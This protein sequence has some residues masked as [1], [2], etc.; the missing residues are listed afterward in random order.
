MHF[1]VGFFYSSLL[2]LSFSLFA[3][4][5]VLGKR[6][7]GEEKKQICPNIPAPIR[8]INQ[9]L[10]ITRMDL[11]PLD[12]SK[13]D[14]YRNRIVDFSCDRLNPLWLNPMF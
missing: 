3:S 14:F 4:G 10:D 7:K 13:S 9:G 11:T 2:L 6:Q 8:M 5:D 1:S 12:A